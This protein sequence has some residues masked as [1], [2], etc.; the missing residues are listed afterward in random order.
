MKIFSLQSISPEFKSLTQDINSIIPVD[1]YQD[2]EALLLNI[3]ECDGV[4]INLDDN[5]KAQEKNI[6][7]IKKYNEEITII[8]LCNNLSEK[9]LQSHQRSRGAADIYFSYPTDIEI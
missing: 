7:K 9:K 3:D 2:I 1:I 5:Q 6:K 4:I 8:V